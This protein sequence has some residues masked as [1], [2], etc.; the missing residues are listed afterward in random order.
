[1]SRKVEFLQEIDIWKKRKAVSTFARWFVL[2][3]G[4]QKGKPMVWA[5]PLF[6]TFL[7]RSSV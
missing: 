4:N 2:R 3:G 1:M 7:D 6:G 5:F